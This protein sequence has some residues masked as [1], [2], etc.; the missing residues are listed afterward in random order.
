MPCNNSKT[1]FVTQ[2]GLEVGRIYNIIGDF[3]ASTMLYLFSVQNLQVSFARFF[4]MA[5]KVN[6]NV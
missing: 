5:V 6:N 1:V 4:D 3:K 2:F